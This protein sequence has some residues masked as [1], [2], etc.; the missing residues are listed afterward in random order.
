MSDGILWLFVMFSGLAAGAGLY[1]MRINVPR[2]FPRRDG[3]VAVDAAAMS[4]DDA[5][6]RF[7]AFVSTG[8]LTLLTIASLVLAWHPAS[9]GEWWWLFAA[10]V[11][12]VERILTLGYFIPTALRFLQP[13]TLAADRAAA[14]A[15][16]TQLNVLRALLSLGGWLC[17]LTAL[18][19]AKTASSTLQ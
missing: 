11:T 6:R 18:S 12:L 9:P 13:E 4:G 15:R 19:M 10:A 5:G 1:E 17:G 14:A 8:P 7:W 16:W 3:V 2:W